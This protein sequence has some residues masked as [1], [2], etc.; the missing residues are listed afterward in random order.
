MA[1]LLLSAKTLFATWYAAI[2]RPPWARAQAGVRPGR[3]G[4]PDDGLIGGPRLSV[5][6]GRL[7]VLFFVLLSC[8][9]LWGT[10]NSA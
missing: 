8:L 7:F 2:R 5:S 9:E 1:A 6:F 3:P 4:L 10:V